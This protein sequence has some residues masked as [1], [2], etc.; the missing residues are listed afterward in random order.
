MSK[1]I[2][3][4]TNLKVLEGNR[5]RRNLPVDEPKP[6]PIEPEMPEYLDEE[7]R[8]VWKQLAPYLVKNGLLTEADGINFSLL[9]Q[10]AS[11]LKRII[12]ALNT[13]NISLIQKIEKPDPDGGVRYEMKGSPLEVQFRLESNL[14]H[15][16]AGEFGLSPRG[17]VGLSV[18]MG[19]S[20]EGEDLIK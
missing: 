3:K 17:R 6:R 20:D 12:I 15:K 14:F 7:A 2:Q 10:T 9:C 19:D 16:L 4:P 8:R 1:G 11:F 13:E 5:G 18:G